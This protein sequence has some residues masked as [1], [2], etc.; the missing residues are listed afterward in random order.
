MEELLESI[1]AH[2]YTLKRDKDKERSQKKKD[3][4]LKLL[5]YEDDSHF[6]EEMIIITWNFKRFLKKKVGSTSKRK[7]KS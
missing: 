1:I 2:E 5:I 3:L 7:D 4:I 6:D